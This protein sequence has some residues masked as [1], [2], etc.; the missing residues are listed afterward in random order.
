MLNQ[1]KVENVWWV[2]IEER[3]EIRIEVHAFYF[4]IIEQNT[5]PNI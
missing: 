4:N 1:F 2:G 3:M 5:L